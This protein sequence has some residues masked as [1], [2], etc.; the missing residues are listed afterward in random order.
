MEA[1]KEFL[2]HDRDHLPFFERKVPKR[3]TQFHRPQVGV[4]VVTPTMKTEVL[5]V[6]KAHD[7]E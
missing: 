2:G 3:R 4:E 1:A 7:R 6:A 5:P